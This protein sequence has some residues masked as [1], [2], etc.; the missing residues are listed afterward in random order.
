MGRVSSQMDR[1]VTDCGYILIEEERLPPIFFF[2]SNIY[3]GEKGQLV[4]TGLQQSLVSSNS[5]VVSPDL[6]TLC[7]CEEDGSEETSTLEGS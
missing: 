1:P 2:A 6:L 3:D 7:C 5:Q 4:A